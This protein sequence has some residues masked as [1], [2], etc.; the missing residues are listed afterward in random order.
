MAERTF[1]ERRL[2]LRSDV[3]A[4]ARVI[5]AAEQAKRRL[6]TDERTTLRLFDLRVGGSP[7]RVELELTHA[8][9]EQR[10]APLVDRLRAPILRALRDARLGANEIGEV[11]LV[12][13]STRLRVMQA[14]AEQIFGRPPLRSL[15]PDEAVAL[16][17][18][19]QA[20]LVAGDAAVDDLVVTDVAPFSL[21]TSVV[22]GMGRA[23]IDG[24]YAPILERGTVIPASR[25]KRFFT[26]SPGQTE[27]R[28]DA[29]QGEHSLCR[30]NQL[31][32][33]YVV[34]GLPPK[35]EPQPIDIRFSYDLNGL[36]EVETTI[37]ATGERQALVVERAPGRL[38]AEEIERARAALA[39]LK[40]HPRDAFPNTT[41]IARAE[42]LY[43]E[44]VGEPREV[45][46]HALARMR[47]AVETA[48][49]ATI[50][51][52]RAAL[53]SLTRSLAESERR[54]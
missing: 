41:A 1:T 40:L 22:S 31:L 45:L 33:E 14:L 19:V 32:G 25:V 27:V 5:E 54:G 46:G 51:P 47:G 11:L 16:G 20:G 38:T 43:L 8:E 28:V 49:E 42:A 24:V 34:R 26:T 35:Q 37:L 21:G 13:G 53:V 12:G 6:T 4:F 50:A 9:A 15:P 18:A 2:E 44:L 10:F 7:I 30:E 52:A 36:L 3:G 23:A 29:Y 48:D 17:A 39:R